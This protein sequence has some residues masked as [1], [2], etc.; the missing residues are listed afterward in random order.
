MKDTGCVQDKLFTS[1]LWKI[2]ENKAGHGSNAY[3]E[4]NGNSYQIKF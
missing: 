1:I 4:V 2:E 3:L